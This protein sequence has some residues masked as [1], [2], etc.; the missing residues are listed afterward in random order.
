MIGWDNLGKKNKKLISKISK[1]DFLLQKKQWMLNNKNTSDK[2]CY[3][4]VYLTP[5]F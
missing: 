4:I 2:F 1:L 3:A 5:K